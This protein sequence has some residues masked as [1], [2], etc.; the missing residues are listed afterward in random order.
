MVEG[1]RLKFIYLNPS[2][3]LADIFTGPFDLHRVSYQGPTFIRCKRIFFFFVKNQAQIINVF[4]VV[5]RVRRDPAL[6]ICSWADRTINIKMYLHARTP[7][8]GYLFVQEQWSS[9]SPSTKNSSRKKK[10]QNTWYLAINLSY[11]TAMVWIMNVPKAGSSTPDVTRKWTRLMR[12]SFCVPATR[13]CAVPGPKQQNQ[14]NLDWKLLTEANLLPL[15][16]DSLR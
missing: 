7:Q 11:K 2:C 8:S 13:N 6:C 15:Q 3:C 1:W 4:H 5:G 14:V 10:Y 12:Y 16:V 9:F